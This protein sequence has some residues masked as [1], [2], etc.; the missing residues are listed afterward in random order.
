MKALV[1]GGHG[2][3][4]SFL[5]EKLLKEDFSVRCLVRKNS[6]LK[7]V[8]KLPIEFIYG[9]ITDKASLI[10]AVQD[11]DYIYHIAGAIKGS[12]QE[13]FFSVNTDGTLNLAEA[14]QKISN[15]KR[16]VFVSSVA[17]VG[18]VIGNEK[19][20]E[21]SECCPVSVYGASKLEAEKL[22]KEKYP[23][24]P[25]TII[26]PPIVYGPRDENFLTFFKF[27]K[28]GFFPKLPPKEKYYSIVYVKDLVE[29]IYLASRSENAKGQTYFISN[30]EIYSFEKMAECMSEPFS[31]TPSFIYVP[32][33]VVR[34]LSFAGDAYAYLTKK[35][36]MLTSKKF[37]ELMAASWICSSEKSFHDFQFKTKVSLLEGMKETVQWLKENRYL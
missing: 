1:T 23:D 26:R 4:G 29:G 25:L 13:K 19:P 15:L 8:K 6:N 33:T 21:D 20:R 5:V 24:L 28:I 22:L 36:I 12:T 34:L 30:P 9:D 7:W 27:A 16:F 14:A 37:P 3:I 11:C 17:A 2:F 10:P 31:K 35:D 18:P 32:K